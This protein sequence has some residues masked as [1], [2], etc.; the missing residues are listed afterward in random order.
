MLLG[1]VS[2]I[3]SIRIFYIQIVIWDYSSHCFYSFNLFPVINVNDVSLC[4]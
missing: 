1:N 2:I 3:F 4:I